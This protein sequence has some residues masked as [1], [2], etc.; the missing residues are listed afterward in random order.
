MTLAEGS[1]LV[2]EVVVIGYGTQS[3]R[4]LSTAISKVSGEVFDNA[5]A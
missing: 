3:R 2:N 4:T 5:P 1:T